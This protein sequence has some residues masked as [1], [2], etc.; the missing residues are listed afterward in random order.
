MRSWP[1]VSMSRVCVIQATQF[2][3]YD[4][5]HICNPSIAPTILLCYIL[6]TTVEELGFPD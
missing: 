3:L 5:Y 4:K 2:V 6:V 1:L